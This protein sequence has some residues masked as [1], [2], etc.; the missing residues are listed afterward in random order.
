[1][2]QFIP[3]HSQNVKA[4]VSTTCPDATSEG[5]Y[6]V[7]GY[8]DDGSAVCGFAF[9][10]ACPYYEAVSADD[11]MCFKTTPKKVEKPKQQVK[12]IEVKPTKKVSS[13]AQ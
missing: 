12:K 4:D 6:F 1:M 13:C 7:R 11:P 3:H 2:P 9:Y 5:A 10:N 8:N